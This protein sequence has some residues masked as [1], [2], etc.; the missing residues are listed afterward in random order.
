MR[1][2]AGG[3]QV[4]KAQQVLGVLGE[5]HGLWLGGVCHIYNVVGHFE[6]SF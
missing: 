3:Q 5:Q 6:F 2:H 1:G 4:Q